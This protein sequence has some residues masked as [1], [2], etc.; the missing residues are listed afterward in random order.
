MERLTM[1]TILPPCRL[2]VDVA[3]LRA[4]LGSSSLL[5]IDARNAEEFAKGHLPGAVNVDT[6]AWGWYDTS[7]AGLQAYT[8]KMAG[9]IAGL[10]VRRQDAVLFYQGTSGMLAARGVWLLHYLGRQRVAMLD[11]GLRD[12]AETGG[13]VTI[14][15]REPRAAVAPGDAPIPDA[16]CLASYTYVRERMGDKASI[17]LDVRA[18][19]EY[20][21]ENVRASR[22]GTIPGSVHL[23]WQECLGADRRFLPPQALRELFVGRGVTPEREVITFCQGG[24]RSS[25]TYLALRQAGYP[26][27]RNFIGSWHEW[28]DRHEL[29]IETP[30][31]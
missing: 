11:G 8:R 27:V 15:V 22:G 25:H 19:D 20:R 3:W 31:R 1:P 2:L 18:D 26:K 12:W 4:N 24:A 21:G 10:G 7:P 9:L 6:Y 30:Q 5:C 16:A 14:E 13:E 23:E 17:I 29:P 28:A